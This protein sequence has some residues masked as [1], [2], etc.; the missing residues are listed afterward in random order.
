MIETP[1]RNSWNSSPPPDPS[2]KGRR[3]RSR[4][5]AH[6]SD[7]WEMDYPSY[8]VSALVEEGVGW[9]AGEPLPLESVSDTDRQVGGLR[10]RYEFKDDAAV[11]GY[12]KENPSLRNL[13]IEA[14]N[15]IQEYFGSNTPVA[16]DVLKEPDAKGS[17]RLFVLILTTLRPKEAV[18]SLD[19]L[20]KDWWLAALTKA[21]GKVTIDVDYG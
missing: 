18:S 1:V 7:K 8:F 17:G 9:R 21:E 2:A 12:L 5:E 3:C 15:K 4:R 14:H 11:E 16:F 20:D 6:A 10:R 13:L 19:A